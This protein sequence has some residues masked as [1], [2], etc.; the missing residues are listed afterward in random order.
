MSLFFRK[1]KEA[2]VVPDMKGR[3]LYGL[4]TSTLSTL[5]LAYEKD[6]SKLYAKVAFE[7]HGLNILAFV[8]ADEERPLLAFD[9]PLEFEV[10]ASETDTILRAINDVNK[11]IHFGAFTLEQG[12]VWYRYHMIVS[13]RISESYVAAVLKMVLDTV[14]ENDDPMNDLIKTRS[15]NANV[16]PMY[17]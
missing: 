6:D 4:V 12:R 10:P 17:G 11:Q 8:K 2:P 15:S 1:E 14:D 5:N 13:G 7:G 3:E 9:C 16:D